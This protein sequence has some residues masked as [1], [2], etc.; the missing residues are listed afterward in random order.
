M[1]HTYQFNSSI[2][3]H[4]RLTAG[5]HPVADVSKFRR[6]V[7]AERHFHW[8]DYHGPSD[9]S[10]RRW[11]YGDTLPAEYWAQD[12]WIS[13]FLNFGLDAPPDGYVWVRYGS[14]ALLVDED[15]GE[16]VEVEYG[17]FY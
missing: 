16:I 14:D 9:Y 2:N 7:T 17:L 13:N 3:T 4:G 15:T 5:H 12:Y 11:S 10:Y 6:N 1:H 8:G